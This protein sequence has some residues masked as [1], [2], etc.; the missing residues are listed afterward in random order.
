[1]SFLWGEVLYW[2]GAGWHGN[3]KTKRCFAA[4]AQTL[5]ARYFVRFASFA[6]FN[7]TDYSIPCG[8][9]TAAIPGR[10]GEM[11]GLWAC[12]KI[13]LENHRGK[14]KIK[15]SA[16]GGVPSGPACSPVGI[17]P[18]WLGAFGKRAC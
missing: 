4:R 11:C 7:K 10:T 2:A 14:I 5:N 16:F 17:L 15:F 12:C 6:A 1:M 3:D 8:G 9:S 13:Q 18:L